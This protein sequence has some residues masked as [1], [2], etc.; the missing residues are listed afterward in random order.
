MASQPST[1]FIP[2]LHSANHSPNPQPAPVIPGPG[3]NTGNSYPAFFQTG[4]GYPAYSPHS[5][6]APFIPPSPNAAASPFIPPTP[7]PQPG[8][9]PASAAPPRGHSRGAPSHD[10]GAY[11]GAPSP[12]MQQPPHLA[13]SMSYFGAGMG[14]YTPYGPMAPQ[15][16]SPYMTPHS[17][18][19]G[20]GMAT[21]F[22]GGGVPLGSPYGPPTGGIPPPGW[23]PPNPYGT[24]IPP[25]APQMGAWGPNPHFPPQMQRGAS[26]PQDQWFHG[27]NA[28]RRGPEPPPQVHDRMDKFTP[29][30]HCMS[31][32][33]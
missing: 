27:T 15:H 9:H 10:F 30:A 7:G 22:A 12:H 3:G 21:P 19:A 11:P 24:P 14:P 17:A 28:Q 31:K 29:G 4:G 16:Y 1:P 5:S 6:A 33:T 20:F 18:P 8:A 32:S 25:A 23:G 2:P 13:P 26:V